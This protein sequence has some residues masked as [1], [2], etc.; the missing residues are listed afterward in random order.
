MVPNLQSIEPNLSGVKSG[1]EIQL[2]MLS[3]ECGGQVELTEIPSEAF[4]IV[5]LPYVPSVRNGHGLDLGWDFSIPA[6]GDAN[7]L[8]VG[9]KAPSSVQFDPGT[10]EKA[11]RNNQ[12][13]QEQIRPRFHGFLLIAFA[14]RARYQI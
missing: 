13:D 9:T 7:S 6:I 12:H 4:V 14:S 11:G 8:R 1:A 10:A 2:H 3:S 5:I